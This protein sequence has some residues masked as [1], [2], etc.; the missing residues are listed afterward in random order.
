MCLH[1]LFLLILFEY[2]IPQI[3]TRLLKLTI[4]LIALLH[5]SAC[6]VYEV[7]L[8]SFCGLSVPVATACVSCTPDNVNV[9]DE[10]L[11]GLSSLLNATGLL[12]ILNMLQMPLPWLLIEMWTSQLVASM[13]DLQDA[14]VAHNDLKPV[15]PAANPH[16]L[17]QA[18]AGS[19]L[20]IQC[21]TVLKT[22]VD[23]NTRCVA[24]HAY[25]GS[26]N[27]EQDRTPAMLPRDKGQ[28]RNDSAAHLPHVNAHLSCTA[29]FPMRNRKQHQ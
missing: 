7:F 13:A 23:L 18:H 3:P 27:S 15:S 12:I 17:K 11:Q 14:N 24:W 22:D 16:A 6:C 19:R 28:T 1:Q 29:V 10:T 4:L 5:P 9:I 2:R 20:S 26:S 21:L 8:M 25:S